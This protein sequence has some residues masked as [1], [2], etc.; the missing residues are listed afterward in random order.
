MSMVSRR[1]IEELQTTLLPARVKEIEEICGKAI[2]YEADWASFGDDVQALNFVDNV[3]C[4][5]VSMAL[6]VICQDEASKGA[7]RDG[8]KSIRLVNVPDK[9]SMKMTFTGAILEL[10]SAYG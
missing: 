4:Q 7:V 8:L 3:S 6:R 9:A 1:K 5:R 2:P 10:R